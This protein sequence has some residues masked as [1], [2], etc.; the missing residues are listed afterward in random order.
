MKIKSN[1]IHFG[2]LVNVNKIVSKRAE[3]DERDERAGPSHFTQRAWPVGAEKSRPVRICNLN[4]KF[5]NSNVW[6]KRV[7]K[8]V[9]S[10]FQTEDCT[11]QINS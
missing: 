8:L 11:R 7:S 4:I 9:L 3:R 10:F 5:Y 6:N 2:S 1:L